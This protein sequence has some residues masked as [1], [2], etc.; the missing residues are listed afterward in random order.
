[1]PPPSLPPSAFWPAAYRSR[2]SRV[3]PPAPAMEMPRAIR[4]IAPAARPATTSVKVSIRRGLEG[5]PEDVVRQVDSL[6]LELLDEL[7]PDAGRLEPAL[8]LALDH[9]G[10]LEDED[11]L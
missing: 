2:R 11:I 4:M 6:H 3:T 5:E 8:D 10:L 7:G 1:M 9:A